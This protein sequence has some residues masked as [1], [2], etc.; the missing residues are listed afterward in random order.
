LG[1]DKEISKGFISD[2][3]IY[4]NDLLFE[5][6][7]VIKTDSN[8]YTGNL[9]IEFD[10]FISGFYQRSNDFKRKS[11]IEGQ[12]KRGIIQRDSLNSWIDNSGKVLRIDELD[13][14]ELSEEELFKKYNIDSYQDKFKLKQLVQTSKYGLKPIINSFTTK[15][16]WI[17]IL[18]IVPTA[19]FFMLLYR[20]QKRLF[21]EHIIFLMHYSCFL[22]ILYSALLFNIFWLIGLSMFLSYIFLVLA[23]KRFYQQSWVWTI[24]KSTICYV[25]YLIIGMFWSGLGLWVSSVF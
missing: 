21:V 6:D 12:K 2:K 15:F 22:F 13:I 16:I 3:A 5:M 11:L 18:S 1:G 4:R 8:H 7:S 19:A 17:T 10:T 9:K 20:R 24:L 25:V 14:N 23:I